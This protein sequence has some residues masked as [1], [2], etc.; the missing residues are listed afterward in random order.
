VDVTLSLA[1]ALA[2]R[3]VT[4]G[5]LAAA[6]IAKLRDPVGTRD[7]LRAMRLPGNLDR[8]LPVVEAFTALGLLVEQETAWAAYV[9]CGLIAL[10]TVVVAVLVV[11]GVRTPCPC[12]GV[13]SSR[14]PTSGLTLAR[15]LVLLA[16]AVLGTAHAT[17]DHWL[18]AVVAAV[19]CAAVV[20]RGYSAARTR[21][22]A[23]A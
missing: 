2:A 23:G 6:A 14:A 18:I 7:A 5:V 21:A 10:F 20:W 1:V 17:R 22:G 12:F 3:G 8:T 13:A 15:N 16:V 19:V 9:A 11:R 4:A